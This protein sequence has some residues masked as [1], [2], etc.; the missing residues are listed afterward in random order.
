MRFFNVLRCLAV[1]LGSISLCGCRPIVQ[2]D[3]IRKF[4]NEGSAYHQQIELFA[5]GRAAHTVF[6]S[7]GSSASTRDIRWVFKEPQGRSAVVVTDFK[8]VVTFKD[9]AVHRGGRG[10]FD[11]VEMEARR[12][13]LGTYRLTLQATTPVIFVSID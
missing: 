9:F 1:L 2:D 12:G 4:V 5:D 3:L 13:F 6:Q 11:K 10:E 7:S 8:S